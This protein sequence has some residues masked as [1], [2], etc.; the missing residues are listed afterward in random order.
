MKPVTGTQRSCLYWKQPVETEIP[1]VGIFILFNFKLK[2][3]LS[4]FPS[5]LGNIWMKPPKLQIIYFLEAV[6]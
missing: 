1:D 3:L 6:N 5:Q 2:V 4:E